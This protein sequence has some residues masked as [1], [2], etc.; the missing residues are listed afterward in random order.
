[1]GKASALAQLDRKPEAIR[2]LDHALKLD[3]NHK[4]AR[5]LKKLLN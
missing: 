1:V 3:P 5:G 2:A 4:R